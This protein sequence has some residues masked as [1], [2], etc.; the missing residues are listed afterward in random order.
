[1]SRCDPFSAATI[2]Y[3]SLLMI[4]CIYQPFEDTNSVSYL[5]N[6]GREHFSSTLRLASNKSISF[7][8][9]RMFSSILI[10]FS[11]YK[12]GQLGHVIRLVT[13]VWVSELQSIAKTKYSC[14]KKSCSVK[15]AAVNKRQEAANHCHELHALLNQIYP[16]RPLPSFAKLP[17]PA[18]QWPIP[19]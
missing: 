13:S 19:Q 1:M 18:K 5:V 16:T 15:W 12:I 6:R 10:L 14:L 2:K 11:K 17:P 7:H 8:I 4:F 9:D 3:L